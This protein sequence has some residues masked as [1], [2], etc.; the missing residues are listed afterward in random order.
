MSVKTLPASAGDWL[1]HES[2]PRYTRDAV[3]LLSTGSVRTI[4]SGTVLGRIVAATP[5][6]AAAA[7]GNTG[8]GAMGAVAVGLGAEPGTYRL[9]MAEAATNGGSF[10]VTAPDGRLVGLGRVGAAFAGG[11]LSFT[12]ADGSTDFAVG[13]AFTI[14]VA[15]GS[16][17]FV[18]LDP[19][20]ALGSARPAAILVDPVTV[21]ATGDAAGL[22]LVRGPAIVRADGLAWPDAFE[23][24]DEAAGRQ[25]LAALGIV[26]R[27][28]A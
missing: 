3:T 16:G 19:E 23:D 20:G 17:G 2:D 24:A 26:A 22:A 14:T 8:D 9:A 7:E 13:D 12:L 18:E 5:A 25:A 28:G 27:T 11:G 10:A 21:P 1:K 6:T 4:P 15:A